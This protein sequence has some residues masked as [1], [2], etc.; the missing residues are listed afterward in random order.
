[1]DVPVI[2]Y[3]AK[4]PFFVFF[5]CVFG[6]NLWAHLN[7]FFDIVDHTVLYEMQEMDEVI[8]SLCKFF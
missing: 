1:M 5:C 4:H 7:F 2:L 3:H 8:M 6:T